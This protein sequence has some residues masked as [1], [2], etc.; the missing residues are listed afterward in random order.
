MSNSKG[1]RARQTVGSMSRRSKVARKNRTRFASIAVLGFDCMRE[2]VSW[3]GLL[4]RAMLAK[5]SK[6]MAEVLNKILAEKKDDHYNGTLLTWMRY[7]LW[8]GYVSILYWHLPRNAVERKTWKNHH[9]MEDS[10]MHNAARIG[11]LSLLKRLKY[12]KFPSKFDLCHAA[13][14]GNHRHVLSYAMHNLYDVCSNVKWIKR[15]WRGL[16]LQAEKRGE[17]KKWVLELLGP[18]RHHVLNEP[19][20]DDARLVRVNFRG[21]LIEVK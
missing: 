16:Y 21:V 6:S 12:L 15:C 18:Y 11:N 2:V 5:T 14:Q 13:V 10:F 9:M 3:M 8:G 1:T 20:L 7:A 19:D 17:E 4:E